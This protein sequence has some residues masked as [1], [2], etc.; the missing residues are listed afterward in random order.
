MVIIR[1]LWF[2]YRTFHPVTEWSELSRNL[3][4][5]LPD[6]MSGNRMVP[7][8]EWHSAIG[9]MSTI[10]LPDMSDNRMSTVL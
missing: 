9:H 1:H 6:E 8:T 4:I 3:A 7:V 2:G 10:R 5:R